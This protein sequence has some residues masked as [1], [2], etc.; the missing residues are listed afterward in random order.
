M[1]SEGCERSGA[2]MKQY[3]RQSVV[4]FNLFSNVN[5]LF[6]AFFAIQSQREDF[7]VKKCFLSCPKYLF[8][9][10]NL[11]NLYNFFLMSKFKL[12]DRFIPSHNIVKIGYQIIVH[13]SLLAPSEL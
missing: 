5:S 12:R 8:L 13:Y 3:F 10:P 7:P 4:S 9:P 2:E 11:G 6:H 1:R